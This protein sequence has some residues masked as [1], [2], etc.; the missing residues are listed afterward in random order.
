MKRLFA[1]MV[2]SLLAFIAVLIGIRLIVAVVP[3]ETPSFT[4]RVTHDSTLA[5]SGWC[6]RD[7]CPGATSDIAMDEKIAHWTDLK[8]IRDSKP[9]MSL[10]TLHLESIVAP[11]WTI[12]ML[13]RQSNQYVQRIQIQPEMNPIT[14]GDLILSV[15][16]PATRRADFAY[17]L[18]TTVFCFESRLCAGM[19]DN[20]RNINYWS[21][22]DFLEY[23]VGD[24]Y[25]QERLL[26]ITRRW[27]GFT[28]NR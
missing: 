6:W 15:G 14:I 19:I 10:T 16:T 13:F 25:V 12:I 24:M 2:G 7:V 23:A 21:K 27:R 18:W 8:L 20:E 5:D 26:P 17:G 11:R 3:H 1:I 9:G 22:V 28:A 4:S